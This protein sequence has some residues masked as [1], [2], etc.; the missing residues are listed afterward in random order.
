VR[1]F[2]KKETQQLRK[3]TFILSLLDNAEMLSNAFYAAS[4]ETVP[5]YWRD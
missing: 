3:Q 4:T 2:P 1:L 5:V